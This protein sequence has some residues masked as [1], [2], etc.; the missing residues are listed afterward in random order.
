MKIA[1]AKSLAGL[2][3]DH[4]LNENYIIPSVFNEGVCHAVADAVKC[5]IREQV[6]HTQ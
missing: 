5:I 3:K 2:V 1:A 4:E 6:K